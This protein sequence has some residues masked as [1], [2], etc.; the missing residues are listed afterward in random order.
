MRRLG[1]E[2]VLSAGAIA[3]SHRETGSSRRETGSSH[4]E[5]GSSHRE[6]GS[7]HRET[8]SSH[9]ETDSSGREPFLVI[10]RLSHRVSPRDDSSGREKDE[11]G[12]ETGS[13]RRETV[14]G[15]REAVPRGELGTMR[16]AA[17]AAHPESALPTSHD[18]HQPQN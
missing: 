18:F 9:R 14:L 2:V 10:V 17:I 16:P 1:Q 4:R 6:T 13:G 3:S 7:S 8:G 11:G 5:T 12:R 15:R